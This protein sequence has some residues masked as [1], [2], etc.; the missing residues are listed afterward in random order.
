[1]TSFRANRRVYLALWF[2]VLA[3][4]LAL[5]IATVVIRV[6]GHQSAS[7]LSFEDQAALDAA[8]GRISLSSSAIDWYWASVNVFTLILF[9]IIG[10]LL[11]RSGKPMGFATYVACMMVAMG[12]ATYPPG[13]ADAYPGSVILQGVAWGLTILA[14]SGMF[15]LPLM[16]PDGR[17]VPRWTVLV[18]VYNVAAF[19]TFVVPISPLFD[20]IGT[21]VLV[22]VTLGSAIYRYRRVSTPDQRRQSRMVLFGFAIGLPCFFLSDAMMRNIDGSKLGVASLAGWLILNPIGFNLAFVMVGLAMLSQ[23]L[24]DVDVVLSRTL[25]W[26]AMSGLVIGVYVGTV[27]ILNGLFQAQHGLLPSLIATGAVAVAF[28]PVRARVQ[29]GVDR[30]IFGKRDDPYSVI[31]EVGHQVAE[32]AGIDD[33]LPQIAR[34]MREALRLPY[35]GV[36]LDRANGPER[37]AAAGVVTVDALHL[38]LIYQGMS[39]GHLEV[40]PRSPGESFSGADRRLLDDLAHQIGI[41]A[42]L[43][44]LTSD[45][46]HSREAIISSR[47]EERRR[48]RRDIHDGL[49][50]QLAALSMQTGVI[51]RQV[52]DNPDGADAALIEM[53]Q[54][55]RVAMD[56]VRR[57]VH[58]LRPPAL[59]ELGL[60]GAIRARLDRIRLADDGETGSPSRV[61]VEI[62]P[63]TLPN[64]PAAV[65]VAVLR[66]VDEAVTNVLRHA[67]ARHIAVRLVVEDQALILWVEDDG[68]GMARTGSPIVPGVGLRSMRERAY[69]LGGT[70]EIGPREGGGTSVVAR[71]PRN[72]GD[73]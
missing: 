18:F 29:R 64:L 46:Q 45:L 20:G 53:R 10:W 39:I 72:I 68:V 28:Q 7:D 32:W 35:V 59:D 21:I 56:D 12:G 43:V 16:F 25:V 42:H 48:L 66:I 8:L 9:S 2:A 52:R 24:F 34:T 15:S 55:I 44:T 73:P 37:V 62:L 33:L 60:A 67:G 50:V 19:L 70:L 71:L 30:L 23:R 57:L 22:V 38:P 31:S 3:A 11:V 47:E 69:E 4:V 6:G 49:G 17:F 58:G 54:E 14:V 27:T 51:R 40:A 65:E 5:Q 41:A 61:E 1:M 63:P 36:L 13:I 26:L